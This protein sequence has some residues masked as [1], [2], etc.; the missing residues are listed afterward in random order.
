V[1]SLIKQQEQQQ[2]LVVWL[3]QGSQDKSGPLTNQR[4]GHGNSI[5]ASHK[6]TIK[7]VLMDSELQTNGKDTFPLHALCKLQK[8][9]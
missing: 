4:P 9:C 1:L 7:H 8:A 5:Q 2:L 3:Q 6:A